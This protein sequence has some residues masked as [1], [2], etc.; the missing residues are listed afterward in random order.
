MYDTREK[1]MR[2]QQWI[3]RE[4]RREALEEGREEGREQG[5]I[6]GKIRT[7]QQ[8]LGQV[9]SSVE[10]LAS[11]DKVELDRLASELQSEL[12]LRLR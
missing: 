9:P 10:E 5:E 11:K 8:L 12:N 7:L 1:A 2:D 4:T 3:L 6:F